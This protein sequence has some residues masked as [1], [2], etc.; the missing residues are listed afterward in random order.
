MGIILCCLEVFTQFHLFACS[1]TSIRSHL[2]SP[3][4]SLDPQTTEAGR[5][6][7]PFPSAC[8]FLPIS[9]R[10]AGVAPAGGDVHGSWS[11][12]SVM[13]LCFRWGL[14]TPW[15][16]TCWPFGHGIILQLIAQLKASSTC[17]GWLQKRGTCKGADPAVVYVRRLQ[18]WL[19]PFDT[20]WYLYPTISHRFGQLFPVA[21]GFPTSLPGGEAAC[22]CI[23][24]RLACG[25]RFV[26]VTC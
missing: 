23:L 25:Q 5:L 2:R 24:K 14:C 21:T 15:C 7:G 9:P 26:L 18:M 13:G 16:T 17:C 6:R 8:L 20:E 10:P 22:A 11:A 1:V 19:V 3:P 12:D 4:L